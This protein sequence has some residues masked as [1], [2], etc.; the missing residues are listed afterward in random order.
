MPGRSVHQYAVRHLQRFPLGTPYTT[1]CTRLAQLFADR[2][3]ARS[4]LVVDQTGVGRPVVDMLKKARIN[5]QIVPV[6]ITAGYAAN[7]GDAGWHVPKKELVSSLQVLLQSRRIKV[8]P[9]LPEAQTLVRELLD[10]KVKITPAANETFGA[11]RKVSTMT[12]CLP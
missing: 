12:W 2:P 5:A 11:L 6:T 1:I 8:A 4:K 10:F 3:L 7:L 9:S